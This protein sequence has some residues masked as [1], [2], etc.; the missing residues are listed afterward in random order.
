MPNHAAI[1]VLKRMILPAL[2]YGDTL[3]IV[4]IETHL[5]KLQVQI[6]GGVKTALRNKDMVNT[7]KQRK[8]I[9]INTLKERRERHIEMA[10]FRA[11]QKDINKDMRDIRTRYHDDTLMKV[12]IPKNPVSNNNLRYIGSP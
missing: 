5:G 10:S 6:N 8:I 2:D 11:A 1:N 3:Y 12:F 7:E 4:C 9:K